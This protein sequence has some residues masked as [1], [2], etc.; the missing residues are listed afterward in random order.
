M[1]I[2]TKTDPFNWPMPKKEDLMSL[3]TISKEKDLFR[4]KT[5]NALPRNR[6]ISQ[7]LDTRDIAGRFYLK[8]NFNVG[9]S[10]KRWIRDS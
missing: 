10:P 7:N 4:V 3:N 8:S 6:T 1:Q 9:A 5:A 2:S